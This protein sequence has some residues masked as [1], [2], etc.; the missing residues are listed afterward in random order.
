MAVVAR[1]AGSAALY[2]KAESAADVVRAMRRVTLA[3]ATVKQRLDTAASQPSLPASILPTLIA[4]HDMEML[5]SRDCGLRVAPS[6]A[7]S[8]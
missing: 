4:P 3:Y 7:S 2:W 1:E 8:V 6:W 5:K